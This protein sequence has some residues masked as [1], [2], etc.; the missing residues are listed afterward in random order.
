M[1]TSQGRLTFT[2]TWQALSKR[3]LQIIPCSRNYQLAILRRLVSAQCACSTA[4]VQS[5]HTSSSSNN[6]SKVPSRSQQ[7]TKVRHS[8]KHTV[9]YTILA[10]CCHELAG[11]WVPSKV[12]EVGISHA[13]FILSSHISWLLSTA[14]C[15]HSQP[16]ACS[17]ISSTNWASIPHTL[18][19]IYAFIP[20][21]DSAN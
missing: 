6:S 3:S 19:C 13:D 20:W 11:S 8:S 10:A 2:R 4:Q 9:D 7:P 16:A 1:A 18:Q 17:N 21:H 12:E 15:S 5:L 14:V